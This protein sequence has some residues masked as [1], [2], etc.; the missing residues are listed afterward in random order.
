MKARSVRRVDAPVDVVWQVLT[1]YEGMAHWAPGVRVSIE[2]H[3]VDRPEGRGAVRAVR[4]AGLTIRELIVDA[5][6]PQRLSY[7]C[8]SGLPLRDYC[9]EVTVEPDGDGS[10]VVWVLSSSA[11]SRT[12]RP[13]LSVYSR[14]FV[15]ALARAAERHH[16]ERTAIGALDVAVPA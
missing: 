5:E 3:G 13:L 6:A 2:R 7:R 11:R 8:I 1:D 15:T 16:L 9:G 4:M 10:W 14:I 12:L